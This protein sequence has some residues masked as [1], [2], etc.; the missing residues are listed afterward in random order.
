MLCCLWEGWLKLPYP[1]DAV[2]NSS[3]KSLT[4]A[5]YRVDAPL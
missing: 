5:R 3:V 4:V 2:R 1:L